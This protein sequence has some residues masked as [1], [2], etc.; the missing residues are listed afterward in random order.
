MFSFDREEFISNLLETNLEFAKNK[1]IR[2]IEEETSSFINNAA[3]TSSVIRETWT[4]QKEPATRFIAGTATV[5]DIAYLDS[6]KVSSETTSDIANKIILKSEALTVLTAKALGVMRE[7]TK[8]LETLV[9]ATNMPAEAK[10]I[11]DAFTVAL[12]A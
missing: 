1:Y 7:Y 5:S 6:L 3:S 10:T 2:D 4:M 9:V 11:K 8:Q 12:F